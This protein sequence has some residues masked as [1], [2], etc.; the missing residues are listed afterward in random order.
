[1]T[2]TDALTVRGNRRRVAQL[3]LVTVTVLLSVA[4]VGAVAGAG[5]ATSPGEPG[6]IAPPGADP[7]GRTTVE[8]EYT[9]E[10]H[11][12]TPT[13]TPSRTAT[14]TS[15]S[16]STPEETPTAT[17][18]SPPTS[19]SG[20]GGGMLGVDIDLRGFFEW[21][22]GWIADGLTGI[23]DTVLSSLLGPIVGTPAPTSDN[24]W[25]VFGTPADQPW[26]GLYDEVYVRF[27]VPLT[28]A[29]V[30]TALAYVGIRAGGTRRGET[31]RLLGRLS[32]AFI[33]ML[34]WFPLASGALQLFDAIGV[35]I[36]TG[37][38]SST[39][40]I[41][42]DLGDA[43]KV[44]GSGV[45]LL[46]VV[47]AVETTLV[48]LAAVAYAVRWLALIVL[49]L[50]M[51]LL[52]AMWALDTWPLSPLASIARR[53]A[54]IY[55]GLLVAGLPAAFLVR[56]AVVAD[57]DFGFGGAF[58]VLASAALIPTAAAASAA[59]VLWSSRQVERAATRSARA[60]EAAARNAPDAA[61]ASRHGTGETLRGARNV[62][63]GFTQRSAIDADGEE[64]LWSGD[65]TAHRIGRRG[66]NAAVRSNNGLERGKQ[67]LG[68][69]RTARDSPEES[70]GA[71]VRSDIERAG[72][73]ARGGLGRAVRETKEKISRW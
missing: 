46:L 12:A 42:N 57:F 27:V 36:A 54:T 43:L 45:V 38:E 34:F 56:I 3:V 7:D 65:S 22:I 5:A 64:T 10:P 50:T 1:M 72:S 29:T 67:R 60:S 21:A 51:P 63:R 58:G 30:V 69:Y 6:P 33:A 25:F 26:A 15:D 47:Y 32:V 71:E 14:A 49:T 68:E 28:G 20:N 13:A 61:R 55:P 24:G 16:Q 8:D 73:Y 2:L 35:V 48:L 31:R 17:G 66:R 23:V 9:P 59:T 39:A 18:G 37:G 4:V 52:A 41:V 62:H 19:G 11:S 44:G 40:A 70:L 53:A